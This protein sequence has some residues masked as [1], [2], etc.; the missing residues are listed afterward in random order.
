MLFLIP[1]SLGLGVQLLTWFFQ[2]L[3]AGPDIPVAIS[4]AITTVFSL[5]S[6]MNSFFPVYQLSL[7]IGIGLAIETALFIYHGINWIIRR[8]QGKFT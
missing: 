2:F 4:S 8:L 1:L 5:A 3:P 6:Q 7:V